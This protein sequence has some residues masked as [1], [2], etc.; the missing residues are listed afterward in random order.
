MYTRNL[1]IIKWIHATLHYLVS[2][3]KLCVN[4]WVQTTFALPKSVNSYCITSNDSHGICSVGNARKHKHKTPLHTMCRHFYNYSRVTGS[5]SWY[6]LFFGSHSNKC[7]NHPLLL[8][9]WHTQPHTNAHLNKLHKALKRYELVQSHT[10]RQQNEPRKVSYVS[11]SRMHP[12]SVCIMIEQGTCLTH[13]PR[14]CA[15]VVHAQGVS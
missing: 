14:A 11:H 15:Q 7:P 1:C 4:D 5:G 8:Q 12:F 3:R 10:L 6:D 13:L 9:P 2:P